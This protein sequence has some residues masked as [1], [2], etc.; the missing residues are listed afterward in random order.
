M[1][2]EHN[3]YVWKAENLNVNISWNKTNNN[4]EKAYLNCNLINKQ[5]QKKKWE[6]SQLWNKIERLKSILTKPKHPPKKHREQT[7]SNTNKEWKIK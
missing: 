3:G 2:I 7:H 6:F 1:E 4:K 5:K